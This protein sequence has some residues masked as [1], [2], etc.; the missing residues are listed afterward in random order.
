MLRH[1]ADAEDATQEALLRIV[2]HLGQF[3]SESRFST[4]AW[5]IAV[6]RIL[7]LSRQRAGEV[8]MDFQAMREDLESGREPQA[9]ERAEDA[10]LLR[11]LKMVCSRAML[12][13]LGP[14]E[15]V[16]FTLGDLLGLS[17]EEAAGVLGIE[18][19]AF[20]K[21]LSRARASLQ[22]FLSSECGVYN[23]AAPCRCH[24]RLSRALELGRV[25]PGRLELSEGGLPEVRQHLAAIGEARRV[26]AF[27]RSDPSVRSRRDLVEALR[28]QL[29]RLGTPEVKA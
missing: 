20:R 23:P 8:P 1:R 6:N 19:P 21:R 14:E 7:D 3:R 4:W 25:V 2:T 15:R 29:R 12:Q 5:R 17:S 27:F 9:P 10:V 11:E 26:T 24:R 13:C 28:L 18:R 16:A 22:Q